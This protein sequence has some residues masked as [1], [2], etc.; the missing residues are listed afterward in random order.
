MKSLSRSVVGLETVSIRFLE[1][2]GPFRSPVNMGRSRSR[3]CQT[4][5]DAVGLQCHLAR[6]QSLARICGER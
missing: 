3:D 2:L 5:R 6:C 1:R 4:G